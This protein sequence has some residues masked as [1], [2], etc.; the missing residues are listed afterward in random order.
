MRTLL[1]VCAFVGAALG[2]PGA[3]ALAVA[4]RSAPTDV[5]FLDVS[6]DPPAHVLIDDADTQAVTPQPHL[7]LKAGHHKLTLVTL[8]GARKR[9]M[10][11]NVEVGQT[12]RLAIHLSS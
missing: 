11:F 2:A 9:T 8:D 5:G 12:T 7:E 4:D 3:R 10:G 6:S 1:T